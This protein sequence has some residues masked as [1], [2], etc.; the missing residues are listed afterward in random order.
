ML[1]NAKVIAIKI[2]KEMQ[3]VGNDMFIAHFR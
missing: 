3:L 2:A 1:K